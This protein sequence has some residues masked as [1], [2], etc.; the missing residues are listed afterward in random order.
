M[1]QRNA[2]YF[3]RSEGGEIERIHRETPVAQEVKKMNWK[4][5]RDGL[6]ADIEALKASGETDAKTL[7]ALAEKETTLKTAINIV[8]RA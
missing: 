4:E 1:E 6:M 3:R 7:Q 2:G 8:G 5:I